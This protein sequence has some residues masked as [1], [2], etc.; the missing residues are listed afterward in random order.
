VGPDSAAARRGLEAVDLEGREGRPR[1]IKS[2]ERIVFNVDGNEVTGRFGPNLRWE[3][4]VV[5]TGRSN[6]R[7]K[8]TNLIDNSRCDLLSVRVELESDNSAVCT[9]LVQCR[10]ELATV[11]AVI[12]GVPLTHEGEAPAKQVLGHYRSC[13]AFGFRLPC[14]TFHELRIELPERV[15]FD[16]ATTATMHNTWAVFSFEV[17][18]KKASADHKLEPRI[19]W[20]LLVHP[21]NRDCKRLQPRSH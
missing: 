11:G 14:E 15:L 7:H 16:F 13:R 10:L 1:T 6:L 17:N 20:R 19:E 8:V 5:K 18:A 12:G 2:N 3:A 21:R 9:H 4:R